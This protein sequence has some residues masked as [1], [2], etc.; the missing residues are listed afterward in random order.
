MNDNIEKRK[1]SITDIL[2]NLDITPTMFKNAE[3][4]YKNIAIFLNEHGLNVDISLQGSFAIGTVTRPYSAEKEKMY[5]VDVICL[6]N[7]DIN[8]SQSIRENLINVLNESL[9]YQNMVKEWPK[10]ITLEYTNLGDFQFRID[11]VPTVLDKNSI[12]EQDLKDSK[13]YNQVLKIA[14][15]EEKFKWYKINP[16]GYQNW[17]NDINE[18]FS[19]Y[20]REQRLKKILENNRNLFTQIEEIPPYFNKSSLQEAIQI[21]KRNRDIYFSKIKNNNHKPSSIILTTFAAII[22]KECSMDIDS[23][24]LALE[25]IVK[26]KQHFNNAKSDN[27]NHIL[28]KG[29]GWEFYNPVN[30][31]D[32]L[33]DSWNNNDD[34][35]K[36]FYEWLVYAEK[37]LKTILD[38]TTENYIE[39][40]GNSFGN[41]ITDKVF[42][43]NKIHTVKNGVKPY[44]E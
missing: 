34:V 27:A 28:N 19:L 39:Y 37:T 6:F 29:R 3:E 20:N 22:A 11:L 33:L 31:E 5:D 1:K 40:I 42:N 17:F 21:L 44:H 12:I 10:C 4:K 8:S 30:S 35:N 41:E 26:F 43:R 15:K 7:E 16:K 25:I 14:V 23:V 9:V 18:K 2:R 32:N 13:Y 36:T 24:D 38:I